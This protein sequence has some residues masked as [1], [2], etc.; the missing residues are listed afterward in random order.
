MPPQASCEIRA[1]ASPVCNWPSLSR[2]MPAMP[3]LVGDRP[4]A[5]LARS[6]QPSSISMCIV[7]AMLGIGQTRPL[8]GA[9]LAAAQWIN[10]QRTRVV[11][12]DVPSGL[13]ARSRLLAWRGRGC[14]RV[15]N[16]HVYRRQ[17][18]PAHGRR[19]GRRRY[20]HGRP[21]RCR[22]RFDA[23]DVDGSVRFFAD[24][25]TAQTQHAQRQ[26]RQHT[27]H[28]RRRGDGGSRATS[29]TRSIDH[30]RR[31][32]L[33]RLHRC[34]GI[35][36]R[37]RPARADVSPLRIDRKPAVDRHRVRTRKKRCSAAGTAM[38]IG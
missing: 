27:G 19:R 30:R 33:R 17:A 12:I 16:D 35:P 38:G 5:R 26:L 3:S 15:G 4:A 21:T 34:A 18:G 32:R 11:A 6:C 25:H 9:L 36:R 14:L 1:I 7:D 23:H 37:S 8:Q 22:A 10:A 24:R 20:G 31:S 29:C 13:D 28:R 2:T